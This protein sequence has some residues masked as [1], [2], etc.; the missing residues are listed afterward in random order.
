MS[1]G[2]AL[3]KELIEENKDKLGILYFP[4]KLTPEIIRKEILKCAKNPFYFIQKYVWIPTPGLP[5]KV[6]VFK[7]LLPKHRFVIKALFRLD[8]VNFLA[9]RRSY[10]TTTAEEM[11]IWATLFYPNIKAA[12]VSYQER[13]YKENLQDIYKI[14]SYL[15]EALKELI[16][17]GSKYGKSKTYIEFANGS[18][19]DGYSAK[20]SP[21]KIG[22][23]LAYPIIYIDEAAYIN[24]STIS[25]SVIPAH[26]DTVRHVKPLGYP[27]FFLLTSTP[28]GREG[29]GK[30]YYEAWL[31]SIPFTLLYDI[32]KEQWRAKDPEKHYY[33]ILLNSDKNYN[34]FVG[35]KLHWS[36]FPYRDEKWAE[37][38]KRE[39]NYYNS[40][41]GRRKWYS[42]YELLFLGSENSLFPDEVLEKLKGAPPFHTEILPYNTQLK[43]W[44]DE[45]DPNDIYVIGIDTAVSTKGDYSAFEIYS[46]KTQ[47]Q[48]AEFKGRYGRVSY[49][50]EVILEAIKTLTRK[51][52]LRHDNFFLA[53]ERNSYGNQVVEAMLHTGLGARLIQHGKKRLDY[54]INTNRETKNQMVN[55]FYQLVVED[56]EGRIHSNDL[57]GELFAIEV[58]S[59]GR[60]E[61]AKGHHDDLFMASALSVFGMELL[62]QQRKLP[63]VLMSSLDKTA[64]RLEEERIKQIDEILDI[65]S[66]KNKNN[67]LELNDEIEE[68]LFDNSNFLNSIF[69]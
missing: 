41:E 51:Y 24:Y 62:K 60:I 54:G 6:D 44:I 5:K 56:P 46:V 13:T 47:E 33:E 53:I 31:S 16:P 49:F 55:L 11:L 42:E 10:K 7:D 35:V 32:E 9:S 28:N 69:F 38:V 1:S 27:Y 15:P 61:A 26:E 37:K 59:N 3:P 22:R 66:N 8:Y 57:I 29:I 43:L 20:S 21:E 23:G 19:I 63:P 40:Y 14:Y 39:L 48:V 2:G 58:K 34:S 67:T 4:E 17:L 12:L 68:T 52:K 30:G 65:F 64:A 36:E 45:F 18:K 50:I 25:G